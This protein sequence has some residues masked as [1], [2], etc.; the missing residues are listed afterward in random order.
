M[1]AIRYV[2]DWANGSNLGD[3]SF[4]QEFRVF[5]PGDVA[6]SG[7]A[8]YST[9]NIVLAGN[10]NATTF[11]DAST[12]TGTEIS[13]TNPGGP[14]LVSLMCD[15]GSVQNVDKVRVCRY[16]TG[17]FKDAKTEV[18]VD[19]VTWVPLRDSAVDGTYTEAMPGRDM[20]VLDAPWLRQG[21]FL[22]MS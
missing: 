14:G 3:T 8:T 16:A 6:L 7:T 21:M 4:W 12:G 11:N 17:V 20:V 18:S 9:P 13:A 19:G 5:G 10:L 15:L 22:A 2:R 1:R